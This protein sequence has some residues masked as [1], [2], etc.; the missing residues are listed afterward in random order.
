M[1]APGTSCGPLLTP[2]LRWSQRGQGHG[3]WPRC[4]AANRPAQ[5]GWRKPKKNAR[6]SAI[7]CAFLIYHLILPLL[8]PF[9]SDGFQFLQ[10]LRAQINPFSFEVVDVIC[11]GLGS[12]G[13]RELTIIT[14]AAYWS[15][16]QAI[17]TQP[18]FFYG[19]LMAPG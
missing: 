6:H 16:I 8:I 14:S 7:G 3:A 15:S 10:L 2:S 9:Y 13:M 17:T 19:Q 1:Q 11:G 12:A 4:G 5:Q 18:T